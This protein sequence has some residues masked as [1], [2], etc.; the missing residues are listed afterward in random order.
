M[1]MTKE[2]RTVRAMEA[3]GKG[4]NCAQAVGLAFSDV[5]GLDDRTTARSLAGFGGG[6]GAQGEVCGVVSGFAFVAG[7][8][9]EGLPAEKGEVYRQVR[10]MTEEFRREYGCIL[11]RE[12]KA[13][14]NAVPCD[15]LIRRGVEITDLYY[16]KDA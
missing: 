1:I 12:L 6:V 7:M 16:R 5:T 10:E 9:G 14:G 2:E 8:K 11:C 15:E 3:R 13:K 4:Y